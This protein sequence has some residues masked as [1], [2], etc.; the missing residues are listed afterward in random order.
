M[1]DDVPAW[2]AV[3]ENVRVAVI[4]AAPVTGDRG[5]STDKAIGLIADAGERGARL[6]VFGETW[7]PGYP[8]F[9]AEGFLPAVM[10]A[11]DYLDQA[12]VIGDETTDRLCEAARAAEID[13]VIG[14]VERDP[15]TL[16]SVYCTALFIGAEGQVLG[17]HRK[18]KPT[19]YERMVWAD[20]D[21][22]G[23]RV[24]QR[25]YGRISALNCWE[26]NI[27]LPGYVLMSEGTEIHIALWPGGPDALT[28]AHLLSRAFASQAACHVLS[29]GGCDPA[30]VDKTGHSVVI[31]PSGEIINGPIIGEQTLIA[32]LQ[33]VPLRTAKMICDVAGS[34]SRRDL[35]EVRVDRRG[36]VAVTADDDD[37]DRLPLPP[38]TV[39]DAGRT[40]SA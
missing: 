32:D 10:G 17:R 37:I 28:R 3:D 27:V 8:R 39:P 12:V 40:D 13:V 29:V 11:G 20:G 1:R 18:L 2:L 5:G 15:E 9:A 16:G 35:F 31:D 23:L 36:P 24:H 33:A 30:A 19:M 21:A 6:A 38:P 22:S 4:Q 34:Y 14:I 25:P 26:H 7:L